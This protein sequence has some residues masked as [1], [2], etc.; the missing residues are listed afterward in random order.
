VRT[1]AR[2]AALVTLLVLWASG[3]GEPASQPRGAID[4]GPSKSAD[5]SNWPDVD[6][7][8]AECALAYPED[9]VRQAIALDGTIEDIEVA[10]TQ[11]QGGGK[12]MRLN[13]RINELFRGDLDKFVVL[14]SWQSILPNEDLTGERVLV[15]TDMSLELAGCGFTRPYSPQD[16]ARWRETYAGL[17]AENCGEE[18]RDCDLGQDLEPVP[19]SCQRKAHAYAIAANIDHGDF[20]FRVL[21][22]N[23]RYLALRL[24]LGA[25]AC[26]PEADKE[27][28]RRCARSKTA[29]FKVKDQHGDLITYE[30]RTRCE[31]VQRLEPAFPTQYC[32][33]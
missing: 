26:P 27:Q 23:E 4:A 28:R 19:A 16:A 20:P 1:S 11:E 3:C 5:L 13:V 32:I 8:A 2:S 24:D 30:R 6:T 21:G 17:P 25:D 31:L 10:P 14:R 33:H 7:A 18:V 22:C 9:L 15:A 29:Y 12:A